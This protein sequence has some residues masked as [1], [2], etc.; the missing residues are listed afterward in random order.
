MRNLFILRYIELFFDSLA[1]SACRVRDYFIEHRV[2]SICIFILLLGTFSYGNLITKKGGILEDAI[3]NKDDPY[4]KSDRYAKEEYGFG[5]SFRVGIKCPDGITVNSLREL[6]IWTERFQEEFGDVVISLSVGIPDTNVVGGAVRTGPYINSRMLETLDIEEWKGEIRNDPA[7]GFLVERDWSCLHI[8]VNLEEDYNDTETLWRVAGIVEE[9]KISWFERWFWKTDIHPKNPNI[10]VSGWPVG[11]GLLYQTLNFDMVTR[12]GGG[13]IFIFIFFFVVLGRWWQA[14][15][16]AGVVVSS[17]WLERGSI[18]IFNLLGVDVL[19]GSPLRERVYILPALTV[20]IVQGVS[21]SLHKFEAYNRSGSWHGAK[22]VDNLIFNTA[23]ISFFGFITLWTFELRSIREMGLISATAILFLFIMATVFV[24]SLGFMAPKSPGAS[25]TRY[26]RAIRAVSGAFARLALVK[27]WKYLALTVMLS[28]L[29]I[30]L[31]LNGGLKIGTMPME[32]LPGKMPHRASEFLNQEGRSGFAPLSILV[33]PE[34]G[35]IY[36]PGFIEGVSEFQKSLYGEGAREVFSIVDYAKKLSLQLYGR[37]IP[38]TREDADLVFSYIER[39]TYP[40]VRYQFWTR[41]GIRVLASIEMDDS[42]SI[43]RFNGRVLELGEK[44]PGLRVL[45]FGD[46]A[47]YPREDKYIRE[48]KPKNAGGGEFVVIF[49]CILIIMQKSRL[50]ASR[51]LSPLLGGV[52]MGVPFVFAS[53]VTFL[54]MMAL[55]IPLDVSTAMITALAINASVDFSIYYVDAYLEALTRNDRDSAVAIAMREKGEIIINDIV[56]D[57]VCFFHLVFSHFIPISR[58]GWM[59]I[60]MIIACGI[61]SLVIMASILRH[62]VEGQPAY[63][64]S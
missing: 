27:A 36:S 5:D 18:G 4:Y 39:G 9:R 33:E 54:L 7:F 30:F 12:V 55:K 35:D 22:G 44:Y 15:F 29:A 14:A 26:S 61:G 42:I 47:L 6:I 31:I 53:A 59:M 2:L 32:Y 40:G 56:L 13:I 24:P 38:A 3:L 28:C 8:V 62:A 19:M 11:R 25:A 64:E 41:E 48:G 45:T 52:I 34:N 60:V 57:S 49:F 46:G 58:L 16:S 37:A 63:E 17:M 10:L 21:F 20:C 43:G 1:L 50:L 23:V 51:R